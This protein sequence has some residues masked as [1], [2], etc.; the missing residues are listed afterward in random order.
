[1]R[2]VWPDSGEKFL[3]HLR[4]FDAGQSL[5]EALRTDGEAFVVET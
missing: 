3:D 4:R 5:V 2:R 1:V